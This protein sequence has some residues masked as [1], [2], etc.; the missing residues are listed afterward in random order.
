MPV[1][2][3]SFHKHS[4][5]SNAL[6]TAFYHSFKEKRAA[7]RAVLELSRASA[8]TLLAVYGLYLLLQLKFAAGNGTSAA[9]QSLDLQSNI[10]TATQQNRN[11]GHGPVSPPSSFSRTI[12]F[13]DESPG[14]VQADR[15]A[16]AGTTV[17]LDAIP[18]REVSVLCL[19][20]DN[21]P[22]GD[23][24]FNNSN[25]N[26][27]E[28]QSLVTQEM[29]RSIRRHSTSRPPRHPLESAASSQMQPSHEGGASIYSMG[30]EGPIGSTSS[31]PQLLHLV[32]CS[33]DSLIN[34]SSNV[35]PPTE[36]LVSL[37]IL[38][39][40]SILISI[41]AIFL[42]D[43]IDAMI[44]RTPLSEAFIGLV[45]LPFVGNVAEH[46]TAITVAVNNKMDLALGVSVGSS[47]QIALFVTPILI[48]AGWI[49]NLSMT[50]YFNLFE[51]VAVVATALLVNFLILDGRTNFLEGSLLCACYVITG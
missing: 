38:L 39:L 24:Y 6:K 44:A 3:F 10:A 13:A 21:H 25:Y 14:A 27:H 49:L 42:T 15:N 9:R 37:I 47:I 35:R 12:R 17:E 46:I 4:P 2:D 31:L 30:R 51:T 16:R 41:C 1:S 48:V 8:V 40:A 32:R 11:V 28:R 5:N 50:L 43:S 26:S 33:H 19:Q 45:I 20:A 36:T 23:N 29:D 22:G 34:P 18:A 7:D